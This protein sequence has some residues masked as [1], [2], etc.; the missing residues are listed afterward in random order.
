MPPKGALDRLTCR[1]TASSCSN[2]AAST[3]DICS[4]IARITPDFKAS[5]HQQRLLL[6]R[7]AYLI[8]DDSRGAAPAL[9]GIR[10][11]CHLDHGVQVRCPPNACKSIQLLEKKILELQKSSRIGYS[12]FDRQL[13]L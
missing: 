4:H 5:C 13:T 6:I 12:A 3:M 11:R 10:P 2:R 9:R 8:N 7:H 1:A